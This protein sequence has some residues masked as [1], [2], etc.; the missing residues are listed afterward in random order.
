MDGVLHFL[1]RFKSAALTLKP[2]R[3]R[4]G[5]I[6]SKQHIKMEKHSEGSGLP[7][8]LVII[9]GFILFFILAFLMLFAGLHLYHS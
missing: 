9:I 7:R 3:E 2:G 1:L 8:W 5:K 6:D 4:Q